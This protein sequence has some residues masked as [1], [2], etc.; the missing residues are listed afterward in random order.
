MEGKK[1][2]LI[3]GSNKGIGLEIARQCGRKG[4]VV[5]LSGRDEKR[6]KNALSMLVRENIDAD[7]LVMDVSSKE[8]IR[9]AA[10]QFGLRKMKINVLINNA[11]ISIEG[12][13]DLLKNDLSILEATFKT[14][15]YGPL[16]VTRHFVPYLTSPGGIIMISSTG[17][18]MTR[19]VGGWSPAYCVSKSSLNALTRH[20]AYELRGKNISVN[21][22]SPGWVRT[23]MGGSSAPLSPE[24]GATT[25][26]WLAAEVNDN[27]TGKFFSNKAE[28]PW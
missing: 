10:R 11:G 13:T 27:V 16:L 23:D 24:Q 7:Y 20:L 28:I 1:V 25:P 19:E 18:S 26:V 22:L 9:E 2:V 15:F 6:V 14:N 8:S 5:I 4:F 21:S 3:T 17:G 12:D